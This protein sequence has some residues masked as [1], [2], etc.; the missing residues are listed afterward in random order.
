[1]KPWYCALFP[2]CLLS[3]CST[4]E[5]EHAPTGT[6][7]ACDAALTGWW[8]VATLKNRDDVETPFLNIDSDCTNWRIVE[9]NDD[10]TLDAPES[11]DSD[12]SI[13]I[14]AVGDVRYIAATARKPG[15]D[16][17]HLVTLLRYGVTDK[18]I[19]VHDG[20]PK[21]AA[22]L[23]IDGAIDGKVEAEAKRSAEPDRD[24]TV[25]VVISAGAGDVAALIERHRL[26]DRP[27]AEL[28]RIDDKTR[29]EL[30]AHLKTPRVDG[31]P[32]PHE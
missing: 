28:Q 17:K 5:F 32:K 23:V 18:G 6:A 25:Q 29:A 24:A 20:D 7:I 13:G 21:I 4:V 14:I 2:I 11:L 27:F 15:Q 19:L 16:G 8:Q 30:D 12:H 10:G 22:H 1:M 26:I 3:A 9:R 31:K